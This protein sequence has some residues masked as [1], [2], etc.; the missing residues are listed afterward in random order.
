MLFR[1]KQFRRSGPG[2]TIA[3]DVVMV[4]LLAVNLAWLVFDW[5]YASAAVQDLLGRWFPTFN[6]FY[7]SVIH[8]NFILIDL[9]FVAVFLTDF[10]VG[11]IVAAVKHTYHRWFFYPFVHWYDLLGCIP[12]SGFRFL[13]LLRIVSIVYRLHKSG[14]IDLADTGFGRIVKKYYGIVMEELADRV[15]IKI[16]G[17]VQQEIRTGGPVLDKIVTDVVK[18]QKESLVEWMSHRIER[19]AAQNYGRYRTRFRSYIRRR[20]NHALA[21]NEQFARIERIPMVGPAMRETVEDAISDL[22]FD[23]VNGIMQDLASSRNRAVIDEGVDLLFDSVTMKEEDTQLNAL[24]IDTL[25]RAIEIVKQQL[26]IQ[27]WKIRD[28][29]ENEEDFKERIREELNRMDR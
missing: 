6:S 12:V 27:Q 20:V 8:P 25:D 4:L 28:L 24:V 1:F 26:R 17:D 21:H 14:V 29:A 3:I 5:L 19:V 13:R 10:F 16:L 2:R 18:P 7:G 23:V 9:L 11:W 22:V 15:A